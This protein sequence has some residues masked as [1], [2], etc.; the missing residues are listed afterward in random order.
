MTIREYYQKCRRELSGILNSDSEGDSAVRI[1]FEDIAQYTPTFIFANGGREMLAETAGRIDAV[2]ARIRQGEPVQ[3]A[4]GK[5]RFMGNDYTVTPDV[6]IP[7]PETAALVDMITDD[8]RNRNDLD[9]LDIGTG[10]GCIAVSLAR[11]MPYAHIHAIDISAKALD[12]AK[13]NATA[14]NVR[15]DFEEADILSLTPPS[16]AAY[17]IIVSN[18]PYIA[19]SE[20]KDMDARVLDYEPAAALFVP[21]SDPLVFYRSIAAYAKKTLRP[22]GRIYLEI[23]SDYPDAVCRLLD[24]HG[25]TDAVALRD[26]RGLYRY[27]T[28]KNAE[29]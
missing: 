8:Y 19:E 22:G 11:A 25:L 24:A 13:Q 26:Y 16:T 2:I 29:P 5:A 18:P 20:R 27:V 23:N 6:L 1:I 4:V 7:R 9:I 21:D 12:V 15:I 14:M 3:Y 10:S 28:A 17:N